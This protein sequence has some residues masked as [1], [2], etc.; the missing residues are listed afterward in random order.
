LAADGLPF[1]HLT[2]PYRKM[3]TQG[4]FP[5]PTTGMEPKMNEQGLFI[6]AN[7]T[8]HGV[9]RQVRPEQMDLTIPDEMSWRPGQTLRAAMN[10][11]TYED[12]CVPGVLNGDAKQPTRPGSTCWASTGRTTTADTAMQP[13]RRSGR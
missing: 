12:A 10:L 2:H 3:A 4:A 8:L 11:Y 9:I 7:E 5:A 13:M 6:R 1:T